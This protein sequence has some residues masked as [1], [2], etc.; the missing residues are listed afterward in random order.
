MIW[1]PKNSTWRRTT[2]KRMSDQEKIYAGSALDIGRNPKRQTNQDHLGMFEPINQE[3]P[4]HLYLICD[5][6][7]GHQFGE[8]ASRIAVEEIPRLYCAARRSMDIEGALQTAIGGAHMAIREYAAS[9]E[10]GGAMGT[11]AV[12]A[13][14]VGGRFYVANVGDSRA[15][16]VR[17]HGI[18][19][20]T[21]DHSR[22]A[23][24][25]SMA[26]SVEERAAASKHR[27]ALTRS[28]S[29]IRENVRADIYSGSFQPG[30]VLVL[31]SDGLWDPVSD[32]RIAGAVR[33]LPPQEA[34]DSL[35]RM[36]NRSGGPDN[37]SVVVVR[38]GSLPQRIEEDTG[39]FKT[40]APMP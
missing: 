3:I 32:R 28:L 22:A 26:D 9:F 37:I 25:E 39:E 8:L 17:Q 4:D 5:G 21:T 2:D 33:R 35:V 27:H 15:Y 13:V 18:Q 11:T 38:H 6:M 14:V 7:G 16:L 40:I 10:D 1:Q 23:A 31:C 29:T 24:I 12:V 20:I 34:A 36:A 19:Q 30:E